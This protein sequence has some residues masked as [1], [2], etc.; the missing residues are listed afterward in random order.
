MNHLEKIIA[1]LD[2]TRSLLDETARANAQLESYADE[3]KDYS[4]GID[5]FI[6]K[7]QMYQEALGKMSTPDKLYWGA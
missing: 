5:D 2:V 7:L 1:L 3:L 6:V 4:L